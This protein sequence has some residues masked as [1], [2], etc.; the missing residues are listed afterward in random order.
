MKQTRYFEWIA[1]EDMGEICVLSHIEFEDGETYLHFTNGDVCNITYVAELTT[2][3][4][5]LKNKVMVEILGPT[6]AWT[7]EKVVPKKYVDRSSGAEEEYE[8]PTLHDMLQSGNGNTANIQRSDVG[9]NKL[10]PPK[11]MV[12]PV[13][14]PTIEEWGKTQPVKQKDV[15]PTVTEKESVSVVAPVTTTKELQNIDEKSSVEFNPVKILYDK[16]KKNETDIDLTLTISLPSKSMYDLANS[17]FEKGGDDLIS[18][19]LKDIKTIVIKNALKIALNQYYTGQFD[20]D[21]TEE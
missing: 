15:T 9:T 3:P 8:I 7:K 6:H 4:A 2:D 11:V 16:C 5:K 18:F 10:I 19:V 21:E 14:L 1:G 20:N 13:P 17:E 12:N